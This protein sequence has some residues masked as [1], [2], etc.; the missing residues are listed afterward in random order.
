MSDNG[1]MAHRE[2]GCN[3]PAPCGRCARREAIVTAYAADLVA[4]DIQIEHL[5]AERNTY[6]ALLQAALDRLAALTTS[7][8]Y[9]RDRLAAVLVEIRSYRQ[10]PPSSR[11]AA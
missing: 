3:P 7:T 11:R 2:T 9:L 4:R 10:Q 1:R 5:Q 6:R 8:R